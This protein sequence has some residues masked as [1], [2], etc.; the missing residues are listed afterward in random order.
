MD[1]R[2]GIGKKM[3]KLL[4]IQE[5]GTMLSDYFCGT[6]GV[7]LPIYIDN[8]TTKKEALD[9]LENE[10]NTV[11]DHI[12]YTAEYHDFPLDR[13]EYEI[14][15]QIAKLSDYVMGTGTMD[16]LVNPDL[17][18]CFDDIEENEETPVLIFTIEFIEN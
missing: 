2:K 9:M 4:E 1:K 8:T 7:M 15:K 16:K 11:W 6:S 3:T 12:E 13:L 18:F 5:R 10:I 14:D 17:D